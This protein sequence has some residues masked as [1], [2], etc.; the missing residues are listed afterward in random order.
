MKF[1]HR[2]D[3]EAKQIFCHFQLSLLVRYAEKQFQI[4]TSHT[5]GYI[6]RKNPKRF[7]V[8]WVQSALQRL[9]RKQRTIV[10]SWLDHPVDTYLF[11]SWSN[12]NFGYIESILYQVHVPPFQQH[13]TGCIVAQRWLIKKFKTTKCVS[14]CLEGFTLQMQPTMLWNVLLVITKTLMEVIQP[15]PFVTPFMW[16]A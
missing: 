16:Y 12:C 15:R 13:Y 14:I 5:L 7:D 4:S 8:C 9:L 11:P 10:G 1:L 6:I 3:S 2:V